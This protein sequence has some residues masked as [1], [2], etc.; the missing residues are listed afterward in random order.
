MA[1]LEEM[2]TARQGGEVATPK[3]DAREFA[4]IERTSAEAHER[5]ARKLWDGAD[6]FGLI[7]AEIERMGDEGYE[8][9][10][11]EGD[12][13]DKVVIDGPEIIRALRAIAMRLDRAVM[14]KA[15]QDD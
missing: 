2:R 7:V 14:V 10:A 1:R 9:I 12:G 11:A 8:A 6:A 15:G 5:I 13:A 4:R 3:H